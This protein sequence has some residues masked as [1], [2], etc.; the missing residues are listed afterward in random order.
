MTH[1]FLLLVYLGQK[2]VSQDM[3]FRDI[4]KCKY[5]AERLNKQPAVP[6]KTAQEGKPKTKSYLAVCEPRL[7]DSAKTKIY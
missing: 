6:N 4:D 7:I 1:A 2:I 3:Y 5:F